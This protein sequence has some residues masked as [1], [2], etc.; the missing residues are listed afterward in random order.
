M[1]VIVIIVVHSHHPALP[2]RILLLATNEGRV[3][4]VVDIVQSLI[5]LPVVLMLPTASVD[6]G[7]ALYS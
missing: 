1:V 5:Y 6:V 7:A 2:H 3:G 4:C